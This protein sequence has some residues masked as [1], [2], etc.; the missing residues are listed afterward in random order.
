M[1]LTYSKENIANVLYY[2][3]FSIYIGY[4][5]LISTTIEFNNTSSLKLII[6]LLCTSLILFKMMFFDKLTVSLLTYGTLFIIVTIFASYV[7]KNNLYI[8]AMFMIGA[9]N[10]PI[11]GIIRIYVIEMTV[12]LL[13]TGLLS[14]KGTIPNYT[15]LRGLKTRNS[16]GTKYPTDF[17]AHVFYVLLGYIY[18]IKGKVNLFVFSIYMILGYTVLKLTDARLDAILIFVIGIIFYLYNL[19]DKEY[20]NPIIDKTYL[21]PLLG[22]VIANTITYY[23]KSS[24]ILVTLDKLLSG[25]LYYGNM[26]FNE[27]P[28]RLFGNYIEQHGWGGTGRLDMLFKYFFI[29]SSFVNSLLSFGI[30]FTVYLII[31]LTVSLKKVDIEYK[32]IFLLCF[33]CVTMSSMID[34]HFLELFYNPFILIGF[35]IFNKKE[36]LND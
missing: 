3:S 2:I 34:Q 19:L 32:K 23:Y 9:Y 24:P 14:Y 8:L 1:E 11:R 13:V 31:L 6:Y 18:L 35:S 27:Y 4:Q 21:A 26:A 5:F 36:K 16:F 25:R 28:V 20:I 22:A 15:Y 12:L 30:V 33:L 29:D 10:V 7:A 17:A